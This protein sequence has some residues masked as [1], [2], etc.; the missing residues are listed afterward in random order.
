MSDSEEN[1]RNALPTRSR[2]LKGELPPEVERVEEPV[3]P[4]GAST[5]K[6]ESDSEPKRSKHRRRKSPPPKEPI[7]AFSDSPTPS[8]RIAKTNWTI[9]LAIGSAVFFSVIFFVARFFY[10]S[11]VS[12]GMQRALAS[13]ESNTHG[14]AETLPQAKIFSAVL[15]LRSSQLDRPTVDLV[16][17]MVLAAL[18]STPNEALPDYLRPGHSTV[19]DFAAAYV[20]MR[21]GEFGQAAAILRDADKKLPPDQFSFLMNDPALREFAREPR[22]MGFY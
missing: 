22:V 5:R 21:L 8:A 19:E 13:D 14:D 16:T 12:A 6:S 2:T 10:D 3:D 11:G 20:A 9:Y 4:E 17:P 18:Q 1:N 15:N 7:A